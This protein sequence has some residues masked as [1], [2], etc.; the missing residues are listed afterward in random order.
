M[1]FLEGMMAVQYENNDLQELKQRISE[2]H[3]RQIEVALDEI[4]NDIYQAYA[5]K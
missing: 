5:S 3:E 2:S 1:M 4:V